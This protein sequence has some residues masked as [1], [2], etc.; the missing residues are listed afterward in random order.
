LLARAIKGYADG[1]LSAQAIATLR[2]IALENAEAELQ[3]AGVV[4]TERRVTWADPT[5][6]PEVSVDLAC[7]PRRR[8]GSLRGRGSRASRPGWGVTRSASCGTGWW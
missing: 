6:L 2:G 3:E 5:E 8:L 4:P 1:V 7:G